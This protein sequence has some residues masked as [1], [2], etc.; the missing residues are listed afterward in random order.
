[1]HISSAIHKLFVHPVGAV[2]GFRFRFYDK[3]RSKWTFTRDCN[4]AP[5]LCK[6]AQQST[7]F[8]PWGGNA[9]GIAI[10]AQPGETSYSSWVIEKIGKAL[11]S[12]FLMSGMLILTGWYL[13]GLTL[14]SN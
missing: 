4:Y 14:G 2:L 10:T 7:P 1:M 8:G 12:P 3:T 5:Y 11:S 13:R 9:H 6:S